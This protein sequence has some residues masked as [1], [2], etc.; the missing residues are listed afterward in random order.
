MVQQAV[1][2]V[3]YFFFVRGTLWDEENVLDREHGDDGGYL[4]SDGNELWS[5]GRYQ[6]LRIDWFGW[7][8]G[9]LLAQSCQVACR[10]VYGTKFYEDLEGVEEG[11]LAGF[12]YEVHLE[13]VFDAHG[14]QVQYDAAQVAP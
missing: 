13:H 7:Q 2:P 8:R 6:Q 12:V 4:R 10:G 1:A 9:H 3:D 11:L 14:L 5:Q